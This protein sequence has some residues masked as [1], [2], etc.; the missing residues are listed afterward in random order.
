MMKM[1][2]MTTGFKNWYPFEI[3]NLIGISQPQSVH[4]KVTVGNRITAPSIFS[5][6]K[7]CANLQ[8]VF[9]CLDDYNE[10]PH[11]GGLINV[12]NL[13]R[14]I[15]EVGKSKSQGLARAHFLLHSCLLPVSTWKKG[16]GAFWG[17]FLFLK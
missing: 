3:T 6:R 16:Q 10:V 12:R 14:T 11:T 15:L 13:L 1:V 2:M 4:S 17:L 9:I 5:T 8:V 7:E